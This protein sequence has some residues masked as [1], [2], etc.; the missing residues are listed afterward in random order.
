[1]SR[2]TIRR[3]NGIQARKIWKPLAA[4]VVLAVSGVVFVF[5]RVQNIQLAD[6]VKRLDNELTEMNKRNMAMKLEV[7]QR[8]KPRA[9]H[10]KIVEFNLNLVNVADLPKVKAP[11]VFSS[12]P[13]AAYVQREGEK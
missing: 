2:N 7:D 5:L 9:L 3:S 1:M 13:N 4:I 11:L 8:M 6:E 12:Y 10:E